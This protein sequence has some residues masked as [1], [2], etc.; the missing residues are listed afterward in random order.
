M[1]GERG[2]DGLDL[3][4]VW[5]RETNQPSSDPLR[6]CYKSNHCVR[7]FTLDA[8]H[9]LVHICFVHFY[10]SSFFLFYRLLSSRV[11]LQILR[12]SPKRSH[13]KGFWGIRAHPRWSHLNVFFA[14]DVINK[15]FFST[16]NGTLSAY[17][18]RTNTTVPWV[19][20]RVEIKRY[21]LH[22]LYERRGF[23]VSLNIPAY[24]SYHFCCIYCIESSDN[25]CSPCK[26]SLFPCAIIENKKPFNMLCSFKPF[27]SS[28]Q[29]KTGSLSAHLSWWCLR[30]QYSLLLI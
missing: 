3:S 23:S 5:S 24:K 27:L 18:P 29:I 15:N 28:I 11:L 16:I 20:V 1:D 9:T 12:Q 13:S 19:G 7:T 21:K 26:K 17:F 22:T 4:A 6:M 25:T 8:T 14:R 30:R 10:Y 2:Q